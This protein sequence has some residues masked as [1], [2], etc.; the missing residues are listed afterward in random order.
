MASEHMD[1]GHLFCRTFLAL[2]MDDVRRH[3]TPT[4]RK[5][6]WGYKFDWGR[7]IDNHLEW[8]GPDDFYWHG[9]G[10]C[11]WE[12]RAKGWDAWMTKNVPEYNSED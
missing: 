2:T 9:S 1:T 6:T 11:L 10:C 7:G 5:K 3:T 4:Q 8:H 12:A